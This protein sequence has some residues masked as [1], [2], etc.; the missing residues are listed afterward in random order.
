MAVAY[1]ADWYRIEIGITTTLLIRRLR[2]SMSA[3]RYLTREAKPVSV[4]PDSNICPIVSSTLVL[5]RC[6]P[7]YLER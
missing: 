3:L 4:S 1:L 2:I 7:R 6:N 5:E